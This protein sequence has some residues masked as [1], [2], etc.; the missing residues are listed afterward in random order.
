MLKGSPLIIRKLSFSDLLKTSI[1]F[2]GLLF[3]RVKRY[4]R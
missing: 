1:L 2:L 4:G 3:P